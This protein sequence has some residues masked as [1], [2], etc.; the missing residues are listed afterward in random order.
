[1]Y[2]YPHIYINTHIEIF[3]YIYIYIYI[4]IFPEISNIKATVIIS[5]FNYYFFLL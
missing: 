3:I 4:Y 2:I 5:L 1:M